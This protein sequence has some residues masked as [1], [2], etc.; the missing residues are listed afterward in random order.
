MYYCTCTLMMVIIKTKM[1]ET[2]CNAAKMTKKYY[3]KT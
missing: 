2:S 3:L 1:A